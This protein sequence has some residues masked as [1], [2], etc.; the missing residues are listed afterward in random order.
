MNK[1]VAAMLMM[2]IIPPAF[3]Q[4]PLADSKTIIIKPSALAVEMVPDI[5]YSFTQNIMGRPL[6]LSMDLLKPYADKPLPAVVLLPA[7]AFSMR[8]NQNLSVSGWIL[9]G[10]VTSSPALPIESYPM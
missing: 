3:A 5:A 2:L 10:P 4:T 6:Q 7:A 1:H 8:P 9:P